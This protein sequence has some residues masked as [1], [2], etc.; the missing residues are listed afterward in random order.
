[1]YPER[2]AQMRATL[3]YYDCLN[4]AP[5]I[6]CP[7][8]ISIGLGD[9]VCPPETAYDLLKALGGPVESNAYPRVRARCRRVLG[10]REYRRLP[11]EALAAHSGAAKMT[12]P[13]RFH[14]LLGRHR[15][16]AGRHRSGSRADRDAVALDRVL[17]LVRFEADQH[18]AVPHLRLT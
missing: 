10:G 16:G 15:R 12:T 3:D 7:M 6:T 5:K 9:D 11:G 2:E 1:M 8:L 14:R 17:D 4:F 13:D 18:R